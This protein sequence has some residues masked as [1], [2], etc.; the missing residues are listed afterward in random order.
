MVHHKGRSVVASSEVE[1]PR[2]NVTMIIKVGHAHRPVDFTFSTPP[3]D[4]DDRLMRLIASLPLLFDRLETHYAGPENISGHV[5]SVS[6]DYTATNL[7][8]LILVDASA[9]A[10]EITLPPATTDGLNLIIVKI[11]DGENVVTITP[12]G[13]ELG[14]DTIEGAASLTLSNQ[15]DKATLIAN[16]VNMW[17]KAGT[18]QV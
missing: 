5:S 8:Y 12:W 15:W 1:I 6:G 10:V 16:G 13:T 17:L 11:D 9:A 4:F 14:S 18:G 3:E 2:E 7:D